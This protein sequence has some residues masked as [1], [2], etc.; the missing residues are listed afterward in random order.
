MSPLRWEYVTPNYTKTPLA[1]LSKEVDCALDGR[2]PTSHDCLA[3]PIRSVLQRSPRITTSPAPIIGHTAIEDDFFL[4]QRAEKLSPSGM[5]RQAPHS[6]GRQV[7]MTHSTPSR[8]Q[9]GDYPG[10]GVPVVKRWVGVLP[11]G[12]SAGDDNLFRL[13][14]IKR[15]VLLGRI[16]VTGHVFFVSLHLLRLLPTHCRSLPLDE[17]TF[18]LTI[19]STSCSLAFG[20]SVQ[21][22]AHISGIVNTSL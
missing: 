4:F 16:L 18:P 3:C 20:L 15:A 19:D 13:G 11:F 2:L 6:I 17:S 7:L 21:L 10:L 9:S 5:A 14:I 1:P 8:H 22:C 12:W